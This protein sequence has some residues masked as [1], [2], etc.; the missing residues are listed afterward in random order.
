[1]SPNRPL[2]FVD[3]DDTLFQTARKMEKGPRYLASVDTQGQPSGYMTGAQKQLVDWLLSTADVVPV[4]ARSVEA[5]Q[6]VQ[7]PFQLGG[8]CAHGGVILDAT[9]NI[10]SHWQARM[11]ED[12][13]LFQKRLPELSQA[14]LALG[15]GLGYSLRSW[16]VAEAG[17]SHYVVA[18]HNGHEDEVLEVVLTAVADQGLLE[19]LYVHRNGNNLAFLP[20]T[21]EKQRAVAEWLRRDRQQQGERLVLGLGDSLS[22]LGF[23]NLCHL[24]ATPA[25]SQLAKAWGGAYAPSR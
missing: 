24:W 3:L 18:K 22:D 17:L 25:G 9:G 1:M 15:Q 20:H 10:D 11:E 16:V 2:V 6:R 8:I 13:G 19:G 12:L 7:L 5:L 14:T 21:L 23:M 4:T